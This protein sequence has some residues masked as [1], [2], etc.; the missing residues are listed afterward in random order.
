MKQVVLLML[1]V[2]LAGCYSREP[3]KTGLEGKTLPSF[4]LLLID[5]TTYF[6]TKDISEG[7]PVALFLFGPHC[8]YSKAQVEEIIEDMDMLK[9]IQFYMFS[10]WP[11]SDIKEFNSHYQLSKYPNITLGQD[12]KNFFV[13][14][15]EAQGVPYIAIYGKDRKLRKAFVGKI[16]GKQIKEIAE[17]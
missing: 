6:D 16:F 10:T 12:Y 15:F 4:K 2:C 13:D 3:E 1:V 14:Y 8:P 17:D 5:S 7:T 11:L 9:G